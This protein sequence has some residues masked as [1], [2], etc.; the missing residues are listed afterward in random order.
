MHEPIDPSTTDTTTLKKH[1]QL[2]WMSPN[3]SDTGTCSGSLCRVVNS[4]LLSVKRFCGGE[5]VVQLF[6]GK[7][8]ERR[9]TKSD[10]S[11]WGDGSFVSSFEAWNDIALVCSHSDIHTFDRLSGALLWHSDVGSDNTSGMPR[12]RIVN[13]HVYHVHRPKGTEVS[14][15]HLVRASV[16]SGSTWDTL[17]SDYK[18]HPNDYS[19]NFEMPDI[20]LS[21]QGDTLLIFQGRQYNFAAIYGR[22][23]LY[24]LNL[25]TRALAWKIEDLVPEGNSSVKPPLVWHDHIFFQGMRTLFCIEAATGNILWQKNYNGS[26]YPSF[27]GAR[28]KV[29]DE[30]LLIAQSDNGDFYAFDVQTG[31]QVWKT[32]DDYGWDKEFVIQEGKIYVVS[33]YGFFRCI[34]AA[35][36]KLEWQTL[37]P[38]RQ[39]GYP[40]AKFTYGG[41]LLNP[42]LGYLYANDGVFWYCLKIE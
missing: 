19:P 20:W 4:D 15:A 42:D 22:I 27:T 10:P 30:R 13:N 25:R 24:A 14:S 31:A 5:G 23:N 21:P 1:F 29:F 18:Q 8:G 34:N 3:S 38:A 6:D 32:D 2:V 28:V 37:P 12:I 35:T 17:Y 39:M 41:V 26:I 36:G 11:E 7:T 9:W 40:S 16:M 33:V